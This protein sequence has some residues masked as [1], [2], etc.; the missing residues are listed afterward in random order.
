MQDYQ[1]SVIARDDTFFGVCHA[2]GEDF[3]FPP[4]LLRLALALA[5]FW[6][7]AAAIGAYAG[8]GLIVGVSRWLVPNP[9]IPAE[10]AH[11]IESEPA[12]APEAREEAGEEPLP[13]AA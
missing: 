9:R 2:L 6:N 1:P 5:L 7:P 3:R 12:P 13:L 11:F 4:N 10:A 8:L